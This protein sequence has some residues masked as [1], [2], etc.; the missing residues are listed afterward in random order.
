[1][2][3]ISWISDSEAAQTALHDCSSRATPESTYSR[4]S[5][6][7]KTCKKFVVQLLD[8]CWQLSNWP[9]VVEQCE[10]DTDEDISSQ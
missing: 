5:T 4:S 2:H 7:F 3:K 6:C 8:V 9:E 1:M 10:E